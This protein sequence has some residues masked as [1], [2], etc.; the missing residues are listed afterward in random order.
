MGRVPIKD[1]ARVRPTCPRCP[2]GPGA[3]DKGLPLP[4]SS[5]LHPVSPSILCR[6]AE[7]MPQHSSSCRIRV[8]PL[9]LRPQCVGWVCTSQRAPAGG[10]AAVGSDLS[11]PWQVSWSPWAS[12]GARDKRQ[13]QVE[14]PG[15]PQNKNKAPPTVLSPCQGVRATRPSRGDSGSCQSSVVGSGGCGHTGSK[16]A[17]DTVQRRGD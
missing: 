13:L 14:Q 12:P 4:P 6:R 9:H 10:S 11:R 16:L 5:P 17:D 15:S 2:A 8:P 1:R 7:V 3:A